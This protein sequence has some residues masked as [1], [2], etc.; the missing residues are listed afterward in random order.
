MVNKI[1]SWAVRGDAADDTCAV[2]DDEAVAL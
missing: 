2:D 1:S